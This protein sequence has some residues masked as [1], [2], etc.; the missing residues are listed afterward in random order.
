MQILVSGLASVSLETVEEKKQRFRGEKAARKKNKKTGNS[1][2]LV[3]CSQNFNGSSSRDKL[4]EAARIMT[5]QKIC[6]IF[7]QEGR[8]PRNVVERFDSGHL[9][10]AFGGL[11]S[12]S[13]SNLKK[14]GNF[15]MLDEK[16]KR[17][18]VR[19]GKQK[20][21]LCPRLVTLSLQNNKSLRLVNVHFPDSSKPIATREAFQLRF[22]MALGEKKASDIVLLMGDF[23]ASTGVISD[24]SDL[25]CGVHGNPHQ[26]AP[27]RKLKA[28]AAMFNLMD[29][30]T[31][32]EQRMVNTYYDI[33]T[34]AGRQIDRAFVTV[35]DRELVRK[36]VNA[37]MIVDSDH[38][39]VRISMAIEKTE[40]LQEQILF[41][42][43]R[44]NF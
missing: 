34:Q 41:L 2:M 42:I 30:T 17:A 18:F 22:E 6:I 40:K 31:W 14:D 19:G 36:C 16:W 27:G 33:K 5:D 20:K 35:Q 28:T 8:R 21:R 15:F 11:G 37:A 29:L 3:A 25:V 10:I 44:A 1:E 12:R 43:K 24:A 9:F 23:N 32:E 4:E 39:S 7:G 38:E 26:D 13:E